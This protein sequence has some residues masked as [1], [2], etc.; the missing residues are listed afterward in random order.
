LDGQKRPLVGICRLALDLPEKV[1]VERGYRSVKIQ[2]NL[3]GV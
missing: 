1:E 3:F 2:H